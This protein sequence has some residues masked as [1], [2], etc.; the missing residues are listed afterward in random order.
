ML[1]LAHTMRKF[2]LGAILA[3]NIAVIGSCVNATPP[4][5]DTEK[6]EAMRAHLTMP[7]QR[8]PSDRRRTL[9]CDQYCRGYK[10]A[11]RRRI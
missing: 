8:C 10:V 1:G 5:S 9:R 7:A 11:M 6:T 3:L 2:T 4:A